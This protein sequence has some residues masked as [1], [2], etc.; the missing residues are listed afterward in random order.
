VIA[1]TTRGARI[2]ETAGAPVYYF[3]PEDVR[4]DLLR[5]SGRRTH[6]EWKGWA[7]YW[8][9]EGRGGVV[10]DA[11]WSYPDPA[12]GYERVRDWL[13]F[14]AGKVDRCRVGDVPVRPQP[15]GFYGG[16]VTPDLVGPIKGEPGT[17]GW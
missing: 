14:Y 16:W 9:L 4:T 5:P 8:S 7:E 12:P 13:A 2:V 3:P 15:G 10:R 17:E 11:A 1:R 6:C